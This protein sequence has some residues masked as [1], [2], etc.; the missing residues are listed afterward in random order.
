MAEDQGHLRRLGIRANEGQL[1][2]H[3]MAVGLAIVIE[4]QKLKET[5]PRPSYQS[6]IE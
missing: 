1:R 3:G 4:L 6:Q 2:R 5:A